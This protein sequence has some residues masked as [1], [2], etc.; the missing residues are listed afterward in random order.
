MKKSPDWSVIGACALTMLALGAMIFLYHDIVEKECVD[1][2]GDSVCI[3]YDFQTDE[4]A[5]MKT[6]S[7]NKYFFEQ[8]TGGGGLF[9]SDLTDTECTCGAEAEK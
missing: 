5:C 6:C 8:S 9:S 7:P 3:Q 2:Y 1:K 4:I